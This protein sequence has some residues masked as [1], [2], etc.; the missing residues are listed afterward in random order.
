MLLKSRISQIGM[1]EGGDVNYLWKQAR[2]ALITSS[3]VWKICGEKG[4]GETGIGYIRS[5]VFESLSGVSS[6]TEI[7]TEATAQGLVQEGPAL[8]KYIAKRQINP[9]QVVVQK[10]IYGSMPMTAC[11]PDGLYCI[12]ESTD[13]LSWNVEVWECKA[14]QCLKH[15]E[16]IEADNSQQLKA[17]NRSLYFQVLDQML[18]VDCLIGRAILFNSELP[19]QQGGHHVID[20]N[21]MQKVV[22]S[23]GKI[24]FPIVEDLKFLQ[25]RK[26]EAIAEFEKIK[27]KIISR[28]TK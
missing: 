10:M 28:N 6:E 25:Q 5:R 26:N 23:K 24:T 17:V 1:I 22:D 4:F 9:K 27:S 14:Y 20:F 16:N 3:N 8:R 21:K 18:N 13:G 19:E 2:L 15:M 12:N 7:T 11:T